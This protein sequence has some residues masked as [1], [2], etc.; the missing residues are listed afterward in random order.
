MGGQIP[1]IVPTIF[2]LDFSNE[3]ISNPGN[4][5]PIATS[6]AAA[7]SGGASV[8]RGNG[9]KTYGYF[10]GGFKPSI[11]GNSSTV[12]RL[13]FSTELLSSP[14]KNL[15]SPRN[16]S[17][18]VT[19]NNYSYFGGND[20]GTNTITRF[21]FSNETSSDPGK[22]L[23]LSI[24]P[25]AST[26]SFNY[27]YFIGGD[28]T[29]Q[30]FTSYCTVM[31]LDFSNETV[32]NP[33]KNT[34]AI[35]TDGSTVSNNDYGYIGRDNSVFLPSQ[36][37]K[38][39]FSTEVTSVSTYWHPRGKADASTVQNNSYGYFCGGRNGPPGPFTYNTIS[40]F[41]LSSDTFSNPGNN[42]PSTTTSSSATSSSFY[43]YINPGLPSVLQMSK[44]DFSTD[45]VSL[46]TSFDEVV[47]YASGFSN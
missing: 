29:S 37:I 30:P 5:L 23:S 44:I 12:K 41:D 21:D 8:A 6:S 27:G 11:P 34:P 45:N 19:N 24:N 17:N 36:I 10:A 40:R 32:S 16:E 46:T 14:A 31:R 13:D 42:L 4:G 20:P 1:T 28:R 2:R 15:T 22:N 47:L 35:I 38:I 18:T 26:E 33:G 7:V 39:N 43:G 9:Y 25:G 3:T